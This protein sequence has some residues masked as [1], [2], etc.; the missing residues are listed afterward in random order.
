M[1][2][3]IRIGVLDG[4]LALTSGH[5]LT[6]SEADGEVTLA[7][8]EAQTK[9]GSDGARI[10]LSSLQPAFIVQRLERDI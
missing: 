9:G 7:L 4:V 10:G 5:G 1:R 8:T 3:N 6:I 2:M